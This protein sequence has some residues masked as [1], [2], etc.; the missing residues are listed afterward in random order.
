[1]KEDQVRGWIDALSQFNIVENLTTE[2]ALVHIERKQRQI[3]DFVD[4]L[5][6]AGFFDTASYSYE[7]FKTRAPELVAHA[8]ADTGNPFSSIPIFVGYENAINHEIMSA[9]DASCGLKSACGNRNVIYGV[10]YKDKDEDYDT[11][12]LPDTLNSVF[13]QNELWYE[14]VVR[15]ITKSFNVSLT[16]AENQLFPGTIIRCRENSRSEG[17]YNNQVAI[18]LTF[19]IEQPWLFD[20]IRAC[21]FTSM[22]K[23]VGKDKHVV[24]EHLTRI[25]I[26][27][28][29]E[30]EFLAAAKAINMLAIDIKTKKLIRIRPSIKYLCEQCERKECAHHTATTNRAR[31]LCF[32]WTPNYA[33]TLFSLQGAT[34]PTDKLFLVS[35]HLFKTHLKRTIYVLATRPSKPKQIIADVLFIKNCLRITY[36]NTLTDVEKF[37]KKHNI[38]IKPNNTIEQILAE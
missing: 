19:Y 10:R 28:E 17:T 30:E 11:P 6:Q 2:D 34:V 24:P 33:S 1:M 4:K 36:G 38:E 8:A 7:F 20:S 32:N 12:M 14:E 26:I 21:T 25:K 29:S 5:R 9:L 37:L 23:F 18:F 15:G 13:L 31:F 22:N 3:L 35:K 16:A 27:G